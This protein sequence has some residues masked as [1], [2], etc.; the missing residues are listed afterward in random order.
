MAWTVLNSG[1][2]MDMLNTALGPYIDDD[3]TYVF[4]TPLS[5]NGA[6]P[7]IILE[8]LGRYAAWIIQN[9]VKSNG[10]TF[11]ASTQHVHWPE[12][13][14]TFTEVTGKPARYLQVPASEWVEK[15][16]THLPNGASTRFG[17]AA[18]KD[19]P[20]VWTWGQNFINWFNLYEISGWNVGLIKR[21]YK[22]LDEILPERTKSV[23][24]WMRKTG[25]TGEPK[26]VLGGGRGAHYKA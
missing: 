23:G 11:G 7:M 26:Q 9:P 13:V 22:F 4:D 17:T 24:E 12:L 20:S 10:L 18:N 25:Y 16:F 1:P 5:P 15:H 14:K 2:Y 8:D 19:D 3:G 21:D 6:M